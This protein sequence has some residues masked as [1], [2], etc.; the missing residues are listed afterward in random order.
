MDKREAAILLRHPDSPPKFRDLLWWRP[1]AGRNRE[2]LRHHDEANFSTQYPAAE[3][4]ARIPST[5][6]DARGPLDYQEPANQGPRQAVGLAAPRVRNPPSLRSGRDFRRVL[7]QG[8]RVGRPG[9][10]AAAVANRDPE[11]PSRLG[12]AVRCKGG[13]VARN[14]VKR[15][16]RAAFR[17]IEPAA[18][19]DFVLRADDRVLDVEYST[20][21]AEL[22][23]ALD[24]VVGGGR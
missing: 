21:V 14:L 24:R 12:L 22:G 7:A 17:Q 8:R 1:R 13:A 15:R 6:E 4:Q 23:S 19:Y 18:G 5:D 9:F 2:R 16:L 20:L 11:E 3:A 10:V